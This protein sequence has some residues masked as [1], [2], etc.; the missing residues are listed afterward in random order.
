[1]PPAVA[2]GG[3]REITV[4]L[5]KLYAEQM[6][7]RKESWPQGSLPTTLPD[8]ILGYLNELNRA[9]GKD[10]RRS[11]FEVQ[12]DAEALAWE[13]LRHS[14]RPE[15]AGLEAALE[16]LGGED[17]AARLAYLEEQLKVIRTAE[18]ARD[19]VVLHPRPAGRI[20]G[21][22]A[23]GQQG[24][25][26]TRASGEGLWRRRPRCQAEGEVIQGFLLAVREC[27]LARQAAASVMTLL[28][29]QLARAA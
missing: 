2:P 25:E 12:R 8:L 20:P 19:R 16:A 6:I 10:Q 21:R 7:A 27:C 3:A 15:P 14:F 18:P 26:E 13:C 23:P 28:D 22:P 17:A 5:A 24:N 1:M 9:V 29:E 11:D 4:L